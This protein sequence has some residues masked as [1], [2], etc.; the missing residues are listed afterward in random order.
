MA[1]IL[2]LADLVMKSRY[3]S[4]LDK[5]KTSC[6]LYSVLENASLRNRG[7]PSQSRSSKEQA[8]FNFMAAVTNCSDFGAPKIKSLTVS[9]VKS[10]VY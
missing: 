7:K 8:S 10:A 4:L 9:I 6:I 3:S 2:Q 5:C 1:T